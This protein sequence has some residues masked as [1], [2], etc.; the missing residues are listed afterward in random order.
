MQSHTA[1]HSD[2]VK[3]VVF[4]RKLMEESRLK[5]ILSLYKKNANRQKPFLL[6]PNF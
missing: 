6:I 2:P 1:R 3:Q 5:D 4:H